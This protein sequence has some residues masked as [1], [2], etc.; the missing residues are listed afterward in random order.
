MRVSI[1]TPSETRQIQLQSQTIKLISPFSMLEIGLDS[2]EECNLI[3]GKDVFQYNNIINQFYLDLSLKNSQ[4]IKISYNNISF[5]LKFSCVSGNY[6]D[7]KTIK[8]LMHFN[9]SL[10]SIGKNNTFNILDIFDAIDSGAITL[11]RVQQ[12]L[13]GYNNKSLLDQLDKTLKQKVRAICSSPK[14]GIKVEEIVQDVSFVKRINTNTLNYLSSH[15]EHWKARTLN[16]LIPKRLKSDIIEDEI[17]IYENLF[18]KMAIDDISDFTT[19]QIL[20]I[21]EAKRTN[22]NARDWESYGYKINDYRR[23]L[24]LQKLLPG[25]TS[26]TLN[27]QNKIFNETLHRWMEISKILVSIRSS[28]FYRKISRKIRIS[29]TIHFTNIIKN[30]QRYKALYDIW[31]LIQ[32]ENQN[33][34]KEKQGI[35]NDLTSV[36]KNYYTNYSSIALIYCMNLLGIK[37]TS[38]SI[39]T[40]DEKGV[41]NINA[42]ALD[43]IFKYKITSRINKYGYNCIDIKL[44]EHV[45]IAVNIPPECIIETE[46]FHGLENIVTYNSANRLLHF[47]KK[48]DSKNI[49]DLRS[50]LHKKQSEV[51]KMN[52][53]QK[54]IYQKTMDTWN[55]FLDNV[56]LKHNLHNPSQRKLCVTPILFDVQAESTTIKRFTDELFLTEEEYICYLLPHTL[57]HYK[58]IKESSLLHRL[59]NYGESYDSNDCDHWK[60]YRIA[61]LPITQID[62]GSIQRLMKFIS[63]HRNKLIME[64]QGELPT[65]CPVCGSKNIRKLDTDSW[66]CDDSYCGIEWGKTRCTKGCKD[67]FHWIRPD[68]KLSKNEFKCESE[69]ELILKKE[70]LFDRYIITDFEFDV[71]SDETLKLYP[72]CPKCGMR[73]FE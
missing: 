43:N 30:D 23:G 5:I 36:I 39:F 46:I 26:D 52:Q 61:L 29:K 70:S 48:L 55:S 73:R 20:A 59:L 64:I 47:H 16:G 15:T 68:S 34:Y 24:L 67:Y 40:K 72:I 14:Q 13:T 19:K 45:D 50:I 58:D 25:D 1:I 7:D 11:L 63:I 31:C 10:L 62:I 33:Q 38:N 28:I 9:N 8:N 54:Y 21:K 65:Y 3:A 44:E 66:K 51:K 57:E 4:I 71:L 53:Q 18:F 49:S 35:S 41:L 37:F 27:E 17:N 2:D 56:N 6:I 69:C 32:K 12:P 60:N 22:K 42:T